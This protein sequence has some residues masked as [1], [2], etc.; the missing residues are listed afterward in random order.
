M[1]TLGNFMETFGNPYVENLGQIFYCNICDYKCFEKND[2]EKHMSDGKHK[3]G[4]NGN[5]WQLLETFGNEK[6]QKGQKGQK[7]NCV[8]Y[9]EKCDYTCYKKYTYERHV[10]STRHINKVPPKQEE[11][12]QKGQNGQNDKNDEQENY[13][14]ECICGKKYKNKSGL[15]K[16]KNK[17]IEVSKKNQITEYNDDEESGDGQNKLL[18]NL[19]IEVLKQNKDLVAEV[20]KSNNTN[21]SN[22]SIVATNDSHNTEN[23]L[24][25]DSYNTTTN[26]TF[27]LQVFLN[28]KC[29]NAMNIMDFVDS[30]EPQLSD[31][32]N[33]GRLGFV[34]GLSNIII[35]NL[36]ALDVTMRPVH[37]N[38]SK[39]ETVYVKDNDEWEKD[40]E[41]KSKLRKAVK[42]I[43]H[44]NVKL[45]PQWKAKYPDYLDSSSANSDKYNNM[46]IEVLGGDDDSNVNENKI[47]KKIV[48]E[49]VIDKNI[50]L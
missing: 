39:R 10:A 46:V 1:E 7:I 30:L 26:N 38:D 29:K 40:D 43:A 33:I 20:C 25:N 50:K 31:L 48:R 35:K 24:I 42:Y 37:C 21:N 16:H 8:Y 47:M 12:G 27:N 14:F 49:V 13:E 34:N 15:W 22:N 23:N 18:Y 41:N 32:E 9:C 19:V 28:E 45:V 3:N 36:K 6:G 2:Y 44:K 11:N 5:F 17:C 4:Q